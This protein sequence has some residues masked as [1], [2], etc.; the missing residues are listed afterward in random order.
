MPPPR[1]ARFTVAAT[2][3]LFVVIASLPLALRHGILSSEGAWATR[4]HRRDRRRLIR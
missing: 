3:N 4:E 1:F 2:R